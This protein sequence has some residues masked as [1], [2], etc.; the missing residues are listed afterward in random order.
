MFADSQATTMTVWI[1]M[2]DQLPMNP[3]TRSATRAPSGGRLEHLLID[4]M[5]VGWLP[6]SAPRRGGL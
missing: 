2:N 1:T 3:V 5:P 6:W 4:R